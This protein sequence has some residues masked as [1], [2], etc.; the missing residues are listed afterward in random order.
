MGSVLVPPFV[1]ACAFLALVGGHPNRNSN[2]HDS[3]AVSIEAAIPRRLNELQFESVDDQVDFISYDEENKP[4]ML[5]A[6]AS[7]GKRSSKR[8]Y[9]PDDGPHYDMGLACYTLWHEKTIV[10]DCWVNQMISLEQC[11]K[12]RCSAAA[13][14]MGIHFCCCFGHECNDAYELEA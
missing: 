6:T 10:Q 9:L 12:R 8:C 13:S 7:G 4:Y 3:G 11:K 2:D 14:T 5:C 1:L